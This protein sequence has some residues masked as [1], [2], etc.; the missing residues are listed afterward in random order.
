MC[1]WSETSGR[2]GG[3]NRLLN[4]IMANPS[5]RRVLA[6]VVPSMLRREAASQGRFPKAP[7]ESG[8]PLKKLPQGT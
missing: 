4:L 1:P 7:W 6:G 3:P 2:L 5:R 8:G